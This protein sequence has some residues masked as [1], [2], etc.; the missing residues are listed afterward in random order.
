MRPLTD[1]VPK[2]LLPVAGE[3]FAHWQLSWLAQQG[4]TSVVYCI[5]HLGEQ[6][7]RFVGGGERWGLTVHYSD[8]GARLVGTGGALRK[9]ADEAALDEEF[10]VLYGDSYLVLDLIDVMA[11]HRAAGRSSLMTVIDAQLAGDPP[12]ARIENDRVVLYDKHP[13]AQ[14]AL[15]MSH[16]DYGL[17]VLSRNV[18]V[19]SVPPGVSDLSELQH[20]L[21]VAD[22]L[23]AYVA[24][25]PYHEIG[26]PQG[27]AA[28]EARFSSRF[29]R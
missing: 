25:E 21:S 28:L 10:F 27:L 18:V 15:S 6:V 26:S 17:S 5:G 7:Q 13:A 29:R 24:T 14:V 8:E 23:T 9:A 2:T 4:V 11:R 19:S 16:T 3:P 20:L 1:A 12:N 22:E